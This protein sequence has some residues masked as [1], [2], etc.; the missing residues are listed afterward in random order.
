MNL[1]D[2][3]LLLVRANEIH[4]TPFLS[5]EQE[6]EEDEDGFDAK[7]NVEIINPKKDLKVGDEFE[8]GITMITLAEGEVFFSINMIGTFEVLGEAAISD[9]S[10]ANAP[11]ELGS[12]LY[13]Y[14]RNLAKPIIEYMGASA[15]DMPFAP[16]SPPLPKKSPTRKKRAQ[17]K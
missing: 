9:L 16:P 1:Y 14:V 5:S 10:H 11:Y 15:V 4:A 6:R 2:V 17:S 12:L 7:L 3:R 13:P 8:V